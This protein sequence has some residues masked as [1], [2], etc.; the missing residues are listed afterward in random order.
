MP[1]EPT[2]EQLRAWWEQEGKP[3]VTPEAV[4]EYYDQIVEFLQAVTV[5]QWAADRVAPYPLYDFNG[6]LVEAVA[7][8]LDPIIEAGQT[9]GPELATRIESLVYPARDI[10]VLDDYDGAVETGPIDETTFVGVHSDG[11]T[12]SLY[13]PL[14][15]PLLLTWIDVPA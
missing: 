15:E 3:P 11:E 6:T 4:A 13:P 1:D 14:P 9:V 7:K 8:Q 12:I 2:D 10:E 5:D